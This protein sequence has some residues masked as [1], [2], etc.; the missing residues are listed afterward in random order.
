MTTP[1]LPDLEYV[2]AHNPRTTLLVSCRSVEARERILL[3]RIAELEAAL[4]QSAKDLAW[5][6]K[7]RQRL[8]DEND[9]LRGEDDDD[10]IW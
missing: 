1:E 4:K 9:K 3:A 5:S 2:W 8:M 7:E 6:A 10:A